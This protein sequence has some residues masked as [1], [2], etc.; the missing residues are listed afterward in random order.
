M[1]KV[2][3]VLFSG[4]RG[5]ASITEALVKHPRIDLTVLVN[6]YDDGLSTGRLRKFIPGM[7]GPS[8]VRKNIS[9]LI[10]KNDPSSL[11]IK[12]LL[13]YR[14]PIKTPFEEGLK[15]IVN[16]IIDTPETFEEFIKNHYLSLSL[17]QFEKLKSYLIFCQDEIL[18]QSK[19]GIHF[20]FNDC[21][22][23]NLFF[24]G[25]FLKE[26]RDFNLA[27]QSLASVC[28]LDGEILNITDGKN[29]VL[30]GLKEDG[31]YLEDEAQVVSKQNSFKLKEIF[32]LD[33]YLSLEEKNHY[34]RGEIEKFNQWLTSKNIF[35]QINPQARDHLLAADII[36]YG[37]GTQHSSL[38]PS[39]LT[40]EVGRL[41]SQNNKA[42]KIFISNILKD[43][44]I[45]SESVNSLISKLLYYLNQ[46]NSISLDPKDLITTLFVHKN[47][48]SKNLEDPMNYLSFDQ[49]KLPFKNINVVMADWEAE[50]GVHSGGRVFDEI[51][52]LVNIKLENKL[53]NIPHSLSIIVP[54]LNEERTVLKTLHD[55]LLLD[56]SLLGLTREIIFVDGGST[57]NTLNLAKSLKGIKVLESSQKMGRGEALRKGIDHSSGNIIAFFPSDGEYVASEIFQL[58]KIIKN[59]EFKV[60]FGS[61]VIKCLDFGQRIMEI[62]EGNRLLFLVSKYGGLLLS[63]ISL[64]K[65]NRFIFD[66]LTSIKIFDA[67]L[68]KNLNL[69]S[70][71]VDLDIEIIVKLSQ[72]KIYL[73]E[74]PVEYKPRT[75]KEGKKTTL[76]D[77]LKAIMRF[78]YVTN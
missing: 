8:D 28:E 57:D 62:Y 77:G 69:K 58:V 76:L 53:V 5:T 60:V 24:V 35:P 74:V 59:G 11:A 20:D 1:N 13:E 3:I 16:F 7:L 45:Q 10:T 50:K 44:E 48:F 25:A 42:E 36:I 18:K 9:R 66:P 30:V 78:F 72:K 38:Y 41:I 68:L 19:A 34:N 21:S 73:L 32:L 54:G 40:C 67:S 17:K 4:G 14:F 63:L 47:E 23:G 75:K 26:K 12:E 6:T 70:K 71:G 51:I 64:L 43:N 15:W 37:P 33:E 29:L 46:K 52:N 27:V 61:R 39:Y 2:K 49:S 22:L 56:F 31:T 55:L 65:Y